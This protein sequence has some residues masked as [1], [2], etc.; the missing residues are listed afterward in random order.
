MLKPG[1][2]CKHIDLNTGYVKPNNVGVHTQG[3]TSMPCSQVSD[4]KFYLCSK[5]KNNLKPITCCY[6]T[7]NSF[8]F[9]TT[10]H[11]TLITVCFTDMQMFNT[12]I[13]WHHCLGEVEFLTEINIDWSNITV[14]CSFPLPI[15]KLLQVPPQVPWIDFRC[16]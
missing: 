2:C 1:T 9:I 13:W 3:F 10:H 4:F 7:S 5:C 6:G 12:S 11:D 15:F 16:W 8:C 14:F